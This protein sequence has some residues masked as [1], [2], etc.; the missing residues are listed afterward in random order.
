MIDHAIDQQLDGVILTGD[1]VDESNRHFEAY[2]PLKK[3]LTRLGEAGIH[4]FAVSGNHDYDV[5]PR[6]H[7]E[8]GIDEFH[9]LGRDGAWQ[10]VP[11]ERDGSTAL[12]L[13]GF[14]FD[15]PHISRTP[16][17][18]FTCPP[19]EDG[20]DVP[21][22]GIVHGDLDAGES[23]YAPLRL[24]D[25]NEQPVAAWLL[26]HIHKPG[27]NPHRAGFVLYPG[28]PQPLGTGE[29][30]GHGPWIVDVDPSGAATAEQLFMATVSYETVEIDLT[31]VETD[32]AFRSTVLAALEGAVRSVTAERPDVKA[33][34]FSARYTGRTPLHSRIRDLDEQVRDDLELTGVS[35]RIVESELSASPDI[36][37]E[38]LAR[39]RDPIGVL[40]RFVLE[41]DAD[42]D[43]SRSPSDDRSGT[44]AFM[45]D[46]RRRA[47]E[48][49][50]KP[51][52]RPL[53]E[54]A[55]G[56]ASLTEEEL[57]PVVREQALRL[58]EEMMRQKPSSR[59]T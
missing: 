13:C 35:A 58:I 8:L 30:G 41:L 38:E 28:S 59:T 52:F 2:G 20:T 53:R 54:Q 55:D 18:T 19:L 21:V 6:L 32:G 12:Y 9:L 56:F 23:R 48:M 51:A 39:G 27:L 42:R 50:R 22:L 1:I 17:D 11:L 37:L 34:M 43:S 29:T 4:A 44:G 47:G 33:V 24:A 45:S 3:G 36:D 57:A 10:T 5:F 14:S 46:F 49:N 16:L 31:G 7:R 25:L 26:G 15:R 40:A